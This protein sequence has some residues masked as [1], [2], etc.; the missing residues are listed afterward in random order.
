MGFLAVF[1]SLPSFMSLLFSP[2][3]TAEDRKAMIFMY[4]KY[5]SA[6]KVGEHWLEEGIENEPPNRDTIMNTVHRFQKTGSIADFPRSGRPLTA[7]GPE[8]TALVLHDLKVH[9]TTSMRK[10][11]TSLHIS[12]ASICRT[13]D[14]LGYKPYRLKRIHHLELQDFPKRKQFCDWYISYIESHPEEESN[15]LWTDECHFSL[16]QHVNTFNC[17]IYS[18]TDPNYYL[19]VKH[20]KVWVTVWC[21]VSAQ[22]LVGPFFFDSMVSAETYQR[23]L[24]I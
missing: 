19:E 17:Y 5:Q 24:N 10:R 6:K 4:G 20:T 9:P 18:Q 15:F 22:G 7:T 2:R 13:I 11:A 14:S 16:D 21:G 12:P 8:S 3:R 23:M 1:F